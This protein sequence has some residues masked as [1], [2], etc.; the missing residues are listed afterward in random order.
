MEY[1]Y[2]LC[3]SNNFLD[4]VRFDAMDKNWEVIN[5]PHHYHPRFSKKGFQS[6]MTGNPKQDIPIFIDLIRTHKLEDKKH[7]F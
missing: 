4:R 6:P 7:R 3:F 2:Q 1:A 5:P